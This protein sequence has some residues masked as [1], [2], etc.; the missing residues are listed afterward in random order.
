MAQPLL[1]AAFTCERILHEVDG[2]LTAVRIVD[3]FTISDPDSS[4]KSLLKAWILVGFRSGEAEGTYTVSF[5]IRPPSGQSSPLGPAAPI[6]LKGGAHGATLI[7]ELAIDVRD[8]GV[9]WID[10][11]LDT[12]VVTSIPITLRRAVSEQESRH[13]SNES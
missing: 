1:S 11:L 10:V 5:T 3:T 12:A 13:L 7:I 6:E 9:Y 8:M 2:V 4:P